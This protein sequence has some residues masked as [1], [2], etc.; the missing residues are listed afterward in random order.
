MYVID[1]TTHNKEGGGEAVMTV[2][3]QMDHIEL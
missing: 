3:D 1:A 2:L